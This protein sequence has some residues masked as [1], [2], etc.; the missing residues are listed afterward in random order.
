[1]Q[2]KEI[3]RD[4]GELAFID[5]REPLSYGSG[6]PLFA[7]NIPL[8]Q[9]ELR[10]ARAVPRKSTRIVLTDDGGRFAEAAAARLERFGYTNVSVMSGKGAAAWAAAGY[11]LFGDIRVLVKAFSAFIEKHAQP[12]FIEPEELKAKVDRRE[13][14]IVLDSRPAPEYRAGNIPG[15]IDAPGPDLLRRFDDLVPSPETLVVVNCMSR[16]RGI[17]GSLSLVQGG[18]PNRIVALRNGT[19]GWRLAGFEL[20]RNANRFGPALSESARQNAQARAARLASGAGIVFVDGATLE[21]WRQD[22]KRTTYVVDVRESEAFLAG[23][24]PDSISVPGGGLIM[25]PDEVAATINA[26]L[27]LVDDDGVRATVTAFW[28]KQ[29]GLF[30]VAVLRSD[31]EAQDLETGDPHYPI[32]GLDTAVATRI[33]TD[34]L[35]GLLARNAVTVIDLGPSATYKTGHIPGAYFAIRSYLA[36]ALT[37]LPSSQLQLVLTSPD[38]WLAYIAAEEAAHLV[39]CPVAVL[40]GGT[41]AWKA[42]AKPMETGSDRMLSPE[43][44]R[45]LRAHERP[46]DLFAN[47]RAYLDWETNLLAQINLDGDAPYRALTA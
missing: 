23:H 22:E 3:I 19:S 33:G 41:S 44:D 26:R 47:M 29:M 10:F 46:G 6:H 16:T 5:V 37:A 24:L 7:V 12:E 21:R 38:G 43:H 18:V 40:E 8:S 11:E 20:E 30:E 1:V 27:V 9:L 42:E 4:R 32:L 45:W 2:V 14:L 31:L 25:H 35:A 15:S 39:D 36:D 17:L 28:L 13:D 34:A